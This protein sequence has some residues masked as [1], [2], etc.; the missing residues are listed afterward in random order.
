MQ[1]AGIE[2]PSMSVEERLASLT[3][4]LAATRTA[5]QQATQLLGMKELFLQ[6]LTSALLTQGVR[7]EANGNVV[8]Q[9]ADEQRALVTVLTQKLED[10]TAA[11]EN[12]VRMIETAQQNVE[13]PAAVLPLNTE[14]AAPASAD[15]EYPDD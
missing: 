13:A 4:D 11:N 14:A 5:L 9:A 8:N 6:C 3:R 12:Y 15:G 7:I 2:I 1:E 10:V